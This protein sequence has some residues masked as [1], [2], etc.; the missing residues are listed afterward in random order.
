M[1]EER[2]LT[3][4]DKENCIF[5][6]MW[7]VETVFKSLN[8]TNFNTNWHH[9]LIATELEKVYIGRKNNL[10]INLPP[11][12]S[13][14]EMMKYFVAWSL[15]A[16]PASKFLY[17]TYSARLA[18]D[19]SKEI[20]DIVLSDIYREIYPHVKIRGDIKAGNNWSTTYG[21]NVYAS[22]SAGTITG[23]GAGRLGDTFAGAIIVDD[24][25]KVDEVHS[26]IKMNKVID[27]FRRTIKTRKNNAN[28]PIVVVQQRLHVD[29]L[30]GFLLRGGDGNRW[31]NI[32]ISAI[33][34]NKKALWEE[35]ES[36]KTLL[37][38][39]KSDPYT[40]SAQYMQ[41][42]IILGGGLIKTEWFCWYDTLPRLEF[43]FIT[44]DTAQ[45]TKEYNDYSVF[46]CWGVSEYK[47]YLLDMTRG[48]WEAPELHSEALNFFKRC[49]DRYTSRYSAIREFLIEDKV[50]GTGLI[51]SIGREGVPV[52]GIKRHKDKLTRIMD[53]VNYIRVG[54]VY[55]PKG[56]NFIED[57]IA[58]CSQITQS[59]TH[60]HDDQVD[61]MVDALDVLIKTKHINRRF[62]LAG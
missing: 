13:K 58:E 10:I 30:S 41:E 34:K 9:E 47:I 62:A 16:N 49:S 27:N 43:L 39:K 50:S 23:K 12:H 57:F 37:A 19:I 28:T 25:H 32:L 36:L 51:Q 38:I 42:P 46:Q 11:R 15:G 3:T 5:N 35:R 44:G 6:F 55:L 1:S 60:R 33:D 18:T 52:K 24:P 26:V 40:F 4:E 17:I 61:C 22:G 20:K 56:R 7:F 59:M 54:S 53:V 48:K 29:D 45:K 14:T 31:D 21:G 8:N 2:R